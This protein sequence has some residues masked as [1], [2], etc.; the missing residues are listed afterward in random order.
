MVTGESRK[1]CQKPAFGFIS[2]AALHIS[3]GSHRLPGS[4]LNLIHRT[5]RQLVY[6][7]YPTTTHLLFDSNCYKGR[8]RRTNIVRCCHNTSGSP[9]FIE[10]STLSYQQRCHNAVDGKAVNNVTFFLPCFILLSESVCIAFLLK[11]K[12][13]ALYYLATVQII[14]SSVGLYFRT[15]VPQRVDEFENILKAS[16]T[17]SRKIEVLEPILSAS[18]TAKQSMSFITNSA[19]EWLREGPTN[20]HV[21]QINDDSDDGGFTENL[22]SSIYASSR[23]EWESEEEILGE[24]DVSVDSFVENPSNQPTVVRKEGSM[25]SM[26]FSSTQSAPQTGMDTNQ[27]NSNIPQDTETE[28]QSSKQAVAAPVVSDEDISISPPN[29]LHSFATVFS[30]FFSLFRYMIAIVQVL[31]M[32]LRDM[33]FR[34]NPQYKTRTSFYPA[35]VSNKETIFSFNRSWSKVTRQFGY[36]PGDEYADIQSSDNVANGMDHA[37]VKKSLTS[38]VQDIWKGW[39]HNNM[40]FVFWKN[41]SEPF[42]DSKRE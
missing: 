41:V 14:C 39:K 32:I 6:S 12:L 10:W 35:V 42:Q 19:L 37:S 27:W 24:E 40:Q 26:V 7:S 5:K 11:R 8:Y 2:F 1:T 21:R 4:L 13:V 22:N 16:T 25:Y 17:N 15:K 29:L 9:P 30:L 38:L 23:E 3:S 28:N 20:S 18:Q 33:W 34:F 31:I 36:F